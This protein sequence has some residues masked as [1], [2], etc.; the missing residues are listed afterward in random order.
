MI[1]GDI[2]LIFAPNTYGYKCAKAIRNYTDIN[3][4]N[5]QTIKAYV[6]IY[7]TGFFGEKNV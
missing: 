5:Y 3:T 6:F 2:F 4:N 1:I 7:P